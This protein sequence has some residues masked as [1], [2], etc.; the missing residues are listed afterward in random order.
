MAMRWIGTTALPERGN[1][2]CTGRLACYD[3]RSVPRA[4][5][6]VPVC[7]VPPPRG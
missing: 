4:N 1:L 3:G 6:A 5:L 7:E 2:G